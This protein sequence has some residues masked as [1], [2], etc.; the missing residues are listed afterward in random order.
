MNTITHLL[1]G[2]S[3]ANIDTLEH[4]DRLLVT[5]GGVLPDIDSFGIVP[6]IITGKTFAWFSRYHHLLAHNLTVGILGLLIVV[7]LA[8]KRLMTGILFMLAFHLHLLCDIVGGRGPDGYQWPIPYLWPFYSE[9][10]ITWE[11]Q[12][13]LNSWPNFVIT[14][15]FIGITFWL[16]RTKGY[17]IVGLFSKKADELV[18]KT[19]RR[20]FPLS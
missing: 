18:V 1:I 12:W 19:I 8:R 3:V 11:H 9:L 5:I 16:A 7:L 2:W 20:R 6:E 10:Q 15:L 17:S 4:R 13:S 14:M